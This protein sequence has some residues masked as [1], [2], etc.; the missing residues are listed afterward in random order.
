MIILFQLENN[1][2]K[3]EKS[4]HI[5]KTME[6]LNNYVSSV[7]I[8]KMQRGNGRLVESAVLNEV[9]IFI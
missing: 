5:N 9:M 8:S 2:V 3:H 6:K 7:V 4:I 1:F